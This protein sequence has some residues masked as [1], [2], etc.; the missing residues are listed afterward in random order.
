[1]PCVLQIA[2]RI[3]MTGPYCKLVARATVRLPGQEDLLNQV[4]FVLRFLAGGMPA[5]LSLCLGMALKE[6]SAG[7]DSDGAL[8]LGCCPLGRP[9]GKS[10]CITH[11]HDGCRDGAITDGWRLVLRKEQSTSVGGCRLGVP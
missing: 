1:M 4:C 8:T 3:W 7:S 5:R 9:I 6:V 2:L 11:I 10:S